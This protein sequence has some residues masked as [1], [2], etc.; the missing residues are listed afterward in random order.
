[1]DQPI[2]TEKFMEIINSLFEGIDKKRIHYIL[3]FMSFV[4]VALSIIFGRYFFQ[5]FLTFV[6][7]VLFAHIQLARKLEFIDSLELKQKSY[8]YN[9]LHVSFL[10]ITLFWIIFGILR[11]FSI[12]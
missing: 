1:M 2:K 7:A 8:Y 11:S 6:Y 5:T 10:F 4:F 12:Y 9:F 3:L